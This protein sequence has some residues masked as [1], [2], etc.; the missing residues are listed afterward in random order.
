MS[1]KTGAPAPITERLRLSSCSVPRSRGASSAAT[2]VSGV[3][4]AAA[5]SITPTT[6]ARS[7]AS[8]LRSW[9]EVSSN[10]IASA[11]PG[12][13]A[14]V[15]LVN[16]APELEAVDFNGDGRVDFSDF[17]SFARGFG[18]NDP[19][20]DLDGDGQTAFNDF[21]AFAKGY[22]KHR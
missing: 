2:P 12:Q 20:F 5:T 10:V 6:F 16:E 18:D 13:S 21:I 8:L 1:K 17:L 3:P 11:L 4:T 19:A 22:G 15:P 7:H 14:F 9:F